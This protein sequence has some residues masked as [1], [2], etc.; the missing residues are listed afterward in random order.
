M[1]GSQGQRRT[2]SFA[3]ALH[4]AVPPPIRSAL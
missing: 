1:L 2:T 3:W 4:R